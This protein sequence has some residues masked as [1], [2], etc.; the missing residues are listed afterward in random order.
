MVEKRVNIK[1]NRV[2]EGVWLPKDIYLNKALSWTAKILIVEI[3][4]L[5]TV[6]IYNNK[7]DKTYLCC[8]ASNKYFAEFLSISEGAVANIL[9]ELRE[10]NMIV[11][12]YFDGRKRY[13][14]VHE[15]ME[16]GFI[17]LLRQPSQKDEHNNKDNNK[18]NK[19]NM[20]YKEIV[21][22]LNE[23]AHTK[24]RPD[25]KVTRKLIDARWEER[26]RLEDFKLAISNCY[27]NW[28]DDPVLFNFIRPQTIFNNKFENYVNMKVKKSINPTRELSIYDYNKKM[29]EQREKENLNS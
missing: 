19:D 27:N 15:N 2:F 7:D 5:S 22:Y 24:Y 28:I 29:S 17:K 26:W 18:D 10:K 6:E 12:E 16:A 11:N 1:N 23:K 3:K 9:T 14:R 21:D 4:S 13:V 8:F 20:P 25:S